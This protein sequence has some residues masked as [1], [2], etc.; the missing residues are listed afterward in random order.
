MSRLSE[1]IQAIPFQ[2]TDY[3]GNSIHLTSYK[4][5]KIL[6]TFFRGA[7][8]PFCNLRLQQLI[9]NHPMF[10]EKGIEII[11]FFG[12]SK[13]EITNYAG[14]QK[15]PFPIIPDPTFIHYKTYGIEASQVGMLKMFIQ[16][17]KMIEVLF[18]SFF[19]LKAMADKPLIPADFLID[20]NFK[21]IKA[22]Y[23]KDFSDH[24]AIKDLLAW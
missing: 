7:S 13:E 8:C 1:N 10:Q 11:A 16:P 24:L 20:E 21:I 3:L 17:K 14:K 6:L 2:T 4:G 5:K 18:S 23:G 22:H 15:A 19:T 12:S 9:Q